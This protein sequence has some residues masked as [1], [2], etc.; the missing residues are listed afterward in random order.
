M[1]AEKAELIAIN[2]L[3]WI[4]HKSSYL[5]SFIGITGVTPIDFRKHATETEFLGSILDFVL[6]K[7]KYTL[8]F[9]ASHD[10]EQESISIARQFL[11]GSHL[12]NW[13]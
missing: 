12:P 3:T 2:A 13:T 4:L 1:D 9:C 11:P 7:D 6:S 10:Y 5:S 8:E